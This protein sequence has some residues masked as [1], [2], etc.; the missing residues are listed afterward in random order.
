MEVGVSLSASGKRCLVCLAVA[1]LALPGTLSAQTG[2][3]AL[4]GTVTDQQGAV[5]PGV[6]V[7]VSNEAAAVVRSTTTDPGGQYRIL[8]L[9]PGAYDI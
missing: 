8:A 5:L 7:T 3:A 4:V 6:T 1:C 2:T 9:P